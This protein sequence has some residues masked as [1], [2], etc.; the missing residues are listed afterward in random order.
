[1]TPPKSV[2]YTHS[3]KDILGF[4]KIYQIQLFNYE[5]SGRQELGSLLYDKL[6]HSNIDGDIDELISYLEMSMPRKMPKTNIRKDIFERLLKLN[7]YYQSNF[8]IKKTPY[9]SIIEIYDDLL[10]IKDY[11]DLPSVR[12]IINRVN[13]DNKVKLKIEYKLSRIPRTTIKDIN[14]LNKRNGH[15]LIKFD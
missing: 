1:M 14:K 8:R 10:F 4:I 11:G 15:F 5:D 13:Q 7:L 9:K 3:R 2:H 12:Y 6:Q